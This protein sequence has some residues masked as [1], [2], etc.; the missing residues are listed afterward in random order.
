MRGV[1]EQARQLIGV[2]AYV[3]EQTVEVA[4]ANLRCGNGYAHGGDHLAAVIA[5]RSGNGRDRWLEEAFAADIAALAVALHQVEQL[6][7][8]FRRAR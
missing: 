1:V 8:G 3:A 5:N 7:H 2:A 4:M 6:Q